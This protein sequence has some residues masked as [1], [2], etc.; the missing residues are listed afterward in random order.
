MKVTPKLEERPI[1][2][3]YGVLLLAILVLL[4]APF[5]VSPFSTI[6]FTEILIM[7]LF[8]I[9]FNLLLGYTG[10]LS[11]GHAAYFSVG[12]YSSALFLL[13]LTPSIPQA[14]LLA[15]VVTALFAAVLGYLCVR[16]DEIYFAMLTLA[17]GQMIY[18]AIWE[19]SSLTG[20]SDGL[21][22]IPKP[23]LS[24]MGLEL[25]ISSPIGYYYF[26]LLIFLGSA[27]ILWRIVQ[28][29]FGLVLRGIR[30][31][32]ERIEFLGIPMR[33]YRLM[34]FTISGAFSGLA[35]AIFAPFEMA[36]TPHIAFWTKSAEPVI[37]SLLGGTRTFLGPA[38]G[39]GIYMIIKNIISTKSE[40]WM[41]FLGSLLILIVVFFP[42]GIVG[43]IKDKFFRK[44]M[45]T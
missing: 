37:M 2:T 30:D 17:F 28:S 15:I 21:V 36:I 22:G 16:L 35:G 38:F 23:S 31:N 4:G 12:A 26:T 18:A 29:P 10:L 39:A 19:W 25:D 9:S 42:G 7:G 45:G 3:R 44:R 24:L 34:A 27:A 20:G 14:V 1:S 11:F 40:Y 6:L 5:V 43:Y 13:K 41:L 32:S 8:A 33:R